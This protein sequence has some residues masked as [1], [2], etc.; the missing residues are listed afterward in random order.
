MGVGSNIRMNKIIG[1]VERFE[2]GEQQWIV[3]DK[4]G[5]KG[6]DKM[7]VNGGEKVKSFTS[8]ILNNPKRQFQN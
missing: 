7:I 4:K 2:S 3:V 5:R 8:K 1:T 6:I